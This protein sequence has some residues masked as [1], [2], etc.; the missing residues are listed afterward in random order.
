MFQLLV[1]LGLGL[2]EN[3]EWAASEGLCL[4]LRLSSALSVMFGTLF[5]GGFDTVGIP[6]FYR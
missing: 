6:I 4:L 2:V 3:E 1:A 5:I